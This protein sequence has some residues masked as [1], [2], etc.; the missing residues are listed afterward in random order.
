M[1][2]PCELVA[3]K[4]TNDRLRGLTLRYFF[5]VFD[6]QNK[7]PLL[8]L[9][10]HVFKNQK[11]RMIKKQIYFA[12]TNCKMKHECV[13]QQIN[14]HDLLILLNKRRDILAQNLTRKIKEGDKNQLQIKKIANTF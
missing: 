9:T 1:S 4:Q 6:K 3:S 2:R 12:S 5:R 13:C 11:S 10:M 8:R 7:I 14:Q